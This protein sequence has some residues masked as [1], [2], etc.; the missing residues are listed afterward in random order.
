MFSIVIVA[1]WWRVIVKVLTP[2]EIPW[3]F[4]AVIFTYM[5]LATREVIARES[6]IRYI[7]EYWPS[8]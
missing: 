3:E 7:G 2:P 4:Y 1:V 5:L 8:F 6:V